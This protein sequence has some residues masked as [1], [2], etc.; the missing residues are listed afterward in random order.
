MFN[1]SEFI[2]ENLTEGYLNR[3][4]FENQVKIFALNYLNRGQIEQETFDRINKFVENN[5][6]YPEETEEDL[7]PP[8]E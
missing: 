8:E 3:S 2:E 5:E 6:P 4:F 7:E 1:L